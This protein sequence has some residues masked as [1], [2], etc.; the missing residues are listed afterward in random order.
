MHLEEVAQPVRV[1]YV[2]LAEVV[3]TVSV[4]WNVAYSNWAGGR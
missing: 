1:V 4:M 2:S 3:G